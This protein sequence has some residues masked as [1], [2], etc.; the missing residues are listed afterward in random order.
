M[1]ELTSLLNVVNSSVATSC[2][3]LTIQAN[4]LR[5]LRRDI[6]LN[7]YKEGTSNR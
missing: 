7:G 5:L 4:N 2:V 3:H 1:C 6:R